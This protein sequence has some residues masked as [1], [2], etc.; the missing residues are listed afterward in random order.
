MAGRALLFPFSGGVGFGGVLTGG[1][2]FALN[3]LQIDL[4]AGGAVVTATNGSASASA[5]APAFGLSLSYR[6]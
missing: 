4:E 1:Y 6:F 2:R 3:A 5:F